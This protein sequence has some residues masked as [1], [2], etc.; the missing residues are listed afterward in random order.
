MW[1]YPYQRNDDRYGQRTM[2]QAEN[3]EADLVVAGQPMLLVA[4]SG[5]A[6]H[7]A[8]QME[9]RWKDTTLCGRPWYHHLS[10]DD[11]DT[12]NCRSCLRTLNRDLTS[13][14]ADARIGIVAQL[15]LDALSEF[16]SS[17]VYGVPGDQT[18]TLRAAIRA[19]ARRRKLR[20]QTTAA[21]QRV[22]LVSHQAW[23]ALDPSIRNQ[24]LQQA[25]ATDLF[26]PSPP[27][28]TPPTP[29]WIINWHTWTT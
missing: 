17:A 6:V 8:G 26:N 16:G 11:E 28:P 1:Q 2:G 3:R 29:E 9:G 18:E 27:T 13:T 5:S 21:D 10:A 24:L 22:F 25:A 4:T 20:L 12:L 15:A 23:E 7:L 19:V 14:E